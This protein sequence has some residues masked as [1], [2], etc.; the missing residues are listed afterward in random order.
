MT[1]PNCAYISTFEATVVTLPSLRTSYVALPSLGVLAALDEGEVL[2]ADLSDLE[3]AAAGADVGVGDLLGSVHDGGA[4]RA[5][6]TKVVRLSQPPV[7]MDRCPSSLIGTEYK[8]IESGSIGEDTLHSG[9]F[10]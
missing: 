5:R 1:I 2:V 10:S 8:A 7:I 6:N 3:E 9:Y 4:A